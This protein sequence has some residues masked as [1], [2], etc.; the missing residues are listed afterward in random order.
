VPRWEPFVG[1]TAA[2]LI[3]LGLAVYAPSRGEAPLERLDGIGDALGDLPQGTVVYNEYA[4]GGWLE[5]RH[6]NVVPV[7][8]GMT[9]AYEVDHVADYVAAGRLEPGW[10]D[11]ID[12]TNANYALLESD[13]RLA[14]ALVERRD[15]R[16]LVDESGLVLLGRTGYE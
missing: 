2:A 16:V 7:I 15:W 11:F 8:D 6:R 12:G 5:W 13:S 1:I 4:L 9:D 14:A 3:V 10:R